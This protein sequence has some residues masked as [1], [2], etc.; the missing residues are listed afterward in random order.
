MN[1]LLLNFKR[2]P[3]NDVKKEIRN[4]VLVSERLSVSFVHLLATYY[5]A[6]TRQEQCW[7]GMA[8]FPLLEYILVDPRERLVIFCLNP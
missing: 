3:I 4:K 5:M 7:H 2:N 8:I 6:D 1:Y